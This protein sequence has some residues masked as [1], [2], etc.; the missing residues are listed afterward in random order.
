MVGDR[1]VGRQRRGEHEAD[2][3]LD[4]HVGG[5]VASAGL[6][7]AIRHQAEP[8]GGPVIMRRLARISHVKLYVVGA[9]ERQEI[10]FNCGGMLQYLWHKLSSGPR[11]KAGC[12]R[13]SR[14]KCAG[15]SAGRRPSAAGPPRLRR[16]VPQKCGWRPARSP[17][18]S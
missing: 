13:P 3:V 6:R 2:L 17:G 14:W 4:E 8:E 11:R 15:S 18:P 16:A 7:S 5:L 10:S 1:V 9:V 12:I